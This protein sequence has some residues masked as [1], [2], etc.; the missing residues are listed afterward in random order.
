MDNAIKKL[1]SRTHGVDLRMK[2][3]QFAG[4]IFAVVNLWHIWYGSSENFSLCM[5][6]LFFYAIGL[7]TFFAA[8][9]ALRGYR[10]TLAF[11]PDAPETLIEQGIYG[12]IRHPFYLAYSITWIAGALAAPSLVTTGSALIMVVFYVSAARVEEAKFL[13]TDL[14]RS[15]QIYRT[16]TGMLWPSS[17]MLV[18]TRE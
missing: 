4:S 2:L 5:T 13:S 7:V 1:F 9:R 12:Y 6:A 8:I 14:A 11:S 10:L 15:Y 16:R 17:V 3:L 18:K